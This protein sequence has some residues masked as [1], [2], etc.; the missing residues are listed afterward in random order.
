MG[1][2]RKKL[3]PRPCAVCEGQHD[4]LVRIKA[5]ERGDW[6]MVCEECWPRFGEDNPG[7]TYGGVWRAHKRR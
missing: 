7:Y 6:M 4:R 5:T 3:A 2:K 1:R